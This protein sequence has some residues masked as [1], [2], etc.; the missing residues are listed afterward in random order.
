MIDKGI[1]AILFDCSTLLRWN[2]PVTGIVRAQLEVAKY[3]L[4]CPY[5]TIF[6][7]FSPDKQA[8]LQVSKE[9]LQA[10]ID[11]FTHYSPAQKPFNPLKRLSAV[12]SRLKRFADAMQ[13]SKILRFVERIQFKSNQLKSYA[14]GISSELSPLLLPPIARSTRALFNK[15]SLFITMGLDWED[16]NYALLYQLKHELKF[17]VVGFF[18]D[19]FILK[20]PQW[21]A[22]KEIV[23]SFMLHFYRLSYL[24]DCIASISEYSKDEFYALLAK[25]RIA[26]NPDV[27]VLHLGNCNKPKE[28]A[29]DSVASAN[30][31]TPATHASAAP[32]PA[33]RASAPLPVVTTPTI[34][35]R[36]DPISGELIGDDSPE[37]HPM[38]EPK[39]KESIRHK[40][41][42]KNV[43]AHSSHFVLYVSTIEPRKNHLLLLDVWQRLAE[44]NL[45][46]PDLVLVGMRGWGADLFWERFKNEKLRQHIFWYDNV[47]DSE[48]QTFYERAQFCVFPSFDEGFG[49]G[50]AESLEHGKPVLISSSRGLCEATQNLMPALDP[51]AP[52]SWA[53]W[54]L[55]LS[56]DAAELQN[57]TQKAQQFARRSWHDFAHDFIEFALE[58]KEAE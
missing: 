34:T 36:R 35:L 51:N 3:L 23:A 50:A 58:K 5:K 22:S 48:L 41:S 37:P 29:T 49:L 13:Q 9:T 17:R 42:R 11:F 27:R 26:A 14:D 32:V 20:N 4:G 18:C 39:L 21:A 10:K 12:P 33:L 55:R 47:G 1:S 54:I 44:S 19:A 24:C 53:E 2:R 52:E 7:A 56:N 43:R 45:H 25:H 31:T 46:F 30:H 8:L 57:L 15:E 6:V 28:A 40:M 16:S 38:L